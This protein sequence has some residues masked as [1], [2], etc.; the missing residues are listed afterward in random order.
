MPGTNVWIEVNATDNVGMRKVRI[1]IDRQPWITITGEGPYGVTWA[2]P[3][4]P[5]R[6]H[7][8]RVKAIDL[9]GNSAIARVRVRTANVE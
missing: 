7:R 1:R 9:A 6:R 5:G 2:V 3:P 4:E 8:I